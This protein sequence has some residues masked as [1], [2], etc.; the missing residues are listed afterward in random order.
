MLCDWTVAI[1]DNYFAITP[2]RRPKAPEEGVGLLNLVIHMDHQHTVKTI[3][4]QFGII[5]CAKL[6]RDII[7]PLTIDAHAKIF[8]RLWQ[9]ILGEHAA[10]C[11]NALRQSDGII[12]VACTNVGHGHTRRNP[13]IVHDIIGL[14]QAVTRVF[15]GPSSG[16]CRRNRTVGAREFASATGTIGAERP[17]IASGKAQGAQKDD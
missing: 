9:N 3:G 15:I 8:N 13:G 12:A 5:G 10:L 1:N 7:E 2:Q 17:T 6:D 11:A 16:D 4:W 14:P